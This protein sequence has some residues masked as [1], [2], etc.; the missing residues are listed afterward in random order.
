MGNINVPNIVING[1]VE[2]DVH[3]FGH[4]ELAEKAQI[5]GTIYYQS[6]EMIK[7]AVIA[8]KLV[9]LDEAQ[10]PVEADAFNL[11]NT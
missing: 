8:G 1:R 11:T 7:G 5:T 9:Q 2:G 3:A 4:V 10:N 6:I